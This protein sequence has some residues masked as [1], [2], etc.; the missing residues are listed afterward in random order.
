MRGEGPGDAAGMGGSERGFWWFAGQ[1]QQLE[2]VPTWGFD[3]L[4]N[5]EMTQLAHNC[6]GAWEPDI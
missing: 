5:W 3:L 2:A 4:C 1:W 6:G